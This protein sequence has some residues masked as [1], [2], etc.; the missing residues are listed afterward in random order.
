MK[1]GAFGHSGLSANLV[2]SGGNVSVAANQVGRG[3]H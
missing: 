2:H 1:K 3:F